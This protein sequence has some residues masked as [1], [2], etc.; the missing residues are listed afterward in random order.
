[1]N[2][3]RMDCLVL[4]MTAVTT[5]LTAA[6]MVFL[7]QAFD[8]APYS[9]MV[10]LVIPI[11]A[12]I[13]GAV[14]ASGCYIAARALNHKPTSLVLAG[15]LGLSTLTFFLVNYLD[16]YL[17]S[18]DGENVRDYISFGR[19][20]AI[21]LDNMVMCVSP[22]IGTGL[23]LGPF[24]YLVAALQILGFFLGGAAVY[25]YLRSAIYCETC[26]RY[27]TFKQTIT[28]YFAD[29]HS[30]SANYE[31]MLALLKGGQY[32]EALAR[33][34]AA[35]SAV[36]Q[37]DSTVASVVQLRYCRACLRHHIRVV[38]KRR[39]KKDWR[40]IPSSRAAVYT[41]ERFGLTPA[42]Q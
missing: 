31:E 10:K 32:E 28:R 16:Y 12:I 27:F 2:K 26:S 6:V 36:R 17:L 11:G 13:S 23:D 42:W 41:A 1:M 9:Y 29:A 19:Y 30:A 4:S 18:V 34:A 33:H 39:E 5:I 22:C 35:G 40:E 7:E 37:G 20:L 15:V 3:R 21:S 38:L 25:G 24:G 8:F 14:A